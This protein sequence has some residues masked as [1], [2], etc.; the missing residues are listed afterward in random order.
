VECTSKDF[1]YSPD[2]IDGTLRI[3][4]FED[5]IAG[6]TNE[7][8]LELFKKGKWGTICNINFGDFE[9]TVSCK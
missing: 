8:R 3:V 5:K 7:G 4:D 2:P 9:A 6:V 1:N